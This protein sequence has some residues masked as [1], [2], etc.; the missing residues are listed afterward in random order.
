MDPTGSGRFQEMKEKIRLSKIVLAGKEYERF[1]QLLR[2]Q[3]ALLPSFLT[4]QDISKKPALIRYTCRAQG[5][6]AGK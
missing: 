3:E 4:P 6:V 1:Q 5:F 2:L